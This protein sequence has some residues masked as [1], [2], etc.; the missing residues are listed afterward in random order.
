MGQVPETVSFHWALPRPLWIKAP[1]LDWFAVIFTSCSVSC[2][3]TKCVRWSWSESAGCY[4]NHKLPHLFQGI[5]RSNIQEVVC[6]NYRNDLPL[7]RGLIQ[8]SNSVLT[9]SRK[10]SYY[11]VYISGTI[12]FIQLLVVL[13]YHMSTEICLKC[14][15]SISYKF[16]KPEISGFTKWIQPS[17]IL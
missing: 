17:M 9:W 1:L 5:L 2:V 10:R 7:E 16:P 3:C 6:W 14:W 15:N 11:V 4:C 13:A 8:C 12:T